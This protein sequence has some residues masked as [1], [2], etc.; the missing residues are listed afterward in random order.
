MLDRLSLYPVIV[1]QDTV[2]WCGHS[3][4]IASEDA[5]AAVIEKRTTVHTYWL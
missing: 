4:T 3:D 1:E 2:K 5:S